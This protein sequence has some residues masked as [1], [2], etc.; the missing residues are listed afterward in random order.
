[1]K[2]LVSVLLCLTSIFLLTSCADT[3]SYC[4][5]GHE[6]GEWIDVIVADCVDDGERYRECT[7]CPYY[8]E[9]FPKADEAL[10]DFANWDVLMEATCGEDG[11]KVCSCEKCGVP[12]IETIPA[13]GKHH[14]EDGA[15]TECG[16][17]DTS[18]MP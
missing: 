2:K 4:E 11:E 15:C 6:F 7:L 1:M 13:T 18:Y 12:T 16:D 10:H 8:E 9:D 5:G 3:T 14:Y 17:I